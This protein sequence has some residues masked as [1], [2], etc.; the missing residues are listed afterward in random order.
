[1]KEHENLKSIFREH[2]DEIQKIHSA[3]E[4]IREHIST[5][6]F[7]DFEILDFTSSFSYNKDGDFLG[8]D[9]HN[10]NEKYS[11][12]PSYIHGKDLLAMYFASYNDEMDALTAKFSSFVT[13]YEYSLKQAYER[14]QIKN[15]KNILEEL[16]KFK[17][18]LN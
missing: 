18:S 16:L 3:F 15:Q 2:Q 7:D 5:Y 11:L 12:S 14:M 1:M 10:L 6:N 17:P 13:T 8:I 4:K 9:V